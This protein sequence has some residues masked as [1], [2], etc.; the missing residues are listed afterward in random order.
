[1]HVYYLTSW[2]MVRD[3]TTVV[4]LKMSDTSCDCIQSDELRDNWIL[5]PLDLVKDHGAIGKNIIY[6]LD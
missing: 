2:E 3:V 6:I 4:E 1:M 5:D